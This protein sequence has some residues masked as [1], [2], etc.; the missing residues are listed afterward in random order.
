MADINVFELTN[1]EL[2]NTN[3]AK[4]SS[5][6]KKAFAKKKKSVT[7][8]V[9][10]RS[11]RVRPFDIS[12]SKIRFES[13][14]RFLEDDNQDD[15]EVTVDYT[16]EDDVVLVIDPDMEEVPDTL[17]DAEAE[18]EKLV[19]QHICKCSI[20][21]ANY[22]SDAQIDEEVEIE[23]EECPVCGE[24]GDQ[25]VVGV[26]TPSDELSDEDEDEISGTDEDEFEEDETEV[27]ETEDG[28]FE[29]TDEEETETETEE[30]EEFGESLGRRHS[31]RPIRRESAK[32]RVPARHTNSRRSID[33]KSYQFDESVLNRMLT[34]FA[35]ENYSNVRSVR[36][37]NGTVRGNKLTLEGVVSTTKGTKRTIKLVSDN[38]RPTAGTTMT[39]KFREI[40]PFTES[41]RNTGYSFIVECVKRGTTI[42]PKALKY[43]FK[44]KN[45]GV[46]ESRDTYSVSGRVI[47]ESS[48]RRT[49]RR[50]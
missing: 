36:I 39:L 34:T 27:E 22:V 25:I 31:R 29:E 28:D 42:I 41:V 43:S 11:H 10:R 37:S 1:H 14:S 3:S 47:N 33:T 13:L 8:S 5:K 21:G 12:A 50:K 38:F 48:K 7:E 4:D 49:S 24:V 9:R 17:E 26:I 32:R 45:A 40:G 6:K 30:D 44:A 16:P 20:C 15:S 19:G 18:A 23:D 35:K 46:R 2:H